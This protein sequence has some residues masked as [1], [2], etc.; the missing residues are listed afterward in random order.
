M[1][2]VR[3]MK[4]LSV[5]QFLTLMAPGASPWESLVCTI[6]PEDPVS[7]THLISF[8]FF[9]FR[10]HPNSILFVLYSTNK[11]AIHNTCGLVQSSARRTNIFLAAHRRGEIIIVV[12]F[13]AIN[14][15]HWRALFCRAVWHREKESF[16]VFCIGKRLKGTAGIEKN[17][18][19]WNVKYKHLMRLNDLSLRGTHWLMSGIPNTHY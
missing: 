19:R 17:Y 11:L 7:Y 5:L 12:A 2:E 3:L 10:L 6:S 9:F 15:F 16:V 1:N 8:F 14:T 18:I 13:W 4:G